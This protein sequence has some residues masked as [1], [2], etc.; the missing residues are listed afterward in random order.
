MANYKGKFEMKSEPSDK[1]MAAYLPSQNRKI[2]DRV[3][4]LTGKQLISLTDF[5]RLLG[6]GR[7]TIYE[8]LYSEQLPPA[9]KIINRRRYWTAEKINDF[10]ER[11]I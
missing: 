7:T 4:I 8:W 5:A 6:K 3:Q 11:Y 2:Q 9:A 1:K 10:S